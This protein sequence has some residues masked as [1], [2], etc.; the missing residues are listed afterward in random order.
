[1][2]NCDG[3]GPFGNFRNCVPAGAENAAGFGAG[4]GRGAGRGMGARRMRRLAYAQAE[5][6]DRDAELE[7]LRRELNDIK[8][9]LGA[10]DK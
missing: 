1:M 7:A 3:T 4:Y 6:M 5:P 8:K 2:P 9:R 10:L